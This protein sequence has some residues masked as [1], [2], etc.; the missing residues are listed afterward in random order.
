MKRKNLILL[1]VLLTTCVLTGC[2]NQQTDKT[3][4]F[5]T[6]PT[7]VLTSVLTSVPTITTIV[8]PN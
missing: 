2:G 1:V 7:A 6:T 8:T 5:T 4:D 3:G